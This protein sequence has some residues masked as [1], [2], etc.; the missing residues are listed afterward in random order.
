MNRRH[1]AIFRMYPVL[2]PEVLL[3]RARVVAVELVAGGVPE[4]VWM[5]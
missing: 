2:V 1:A 3:D 4:Q 5:N